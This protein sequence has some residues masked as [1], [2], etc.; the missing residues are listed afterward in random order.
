[1]YAIHHRDA[2]I[3]VQAGTRPGNPLK[4]NEDALVFN[5]SDDVYGVIDGV[6]ALA[7]YQSDLGFTGGYLAAQLLA[8]V[9]QTGSP[10][11]NLKETVLKANAQLNKRMREACI[12]L[13]DK[14]ALWGAVFAVIKIHD[15]EI[16][17]VQSG[18]CMLLAKYRDGGVRAFTRNQVAA[19]DRITLDAKRQLAESGRLTD[20]EIVQQLQPLF[21]KNRNKANTPDG[22]SVM[23]GDPALAD[24]MES[25]RFPKGDIHKIYAVS[26]GMFHFIE[27]DD[28]PDKWQKFAV[29]LEE[30]GIES[31]MD[32]LTLQEEFDVLCLKYP[33][34]KIS[35]DK[36]AVVLE[37]L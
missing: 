22:Y 20:E 31:F 7:S 29:Q 11:L 25:G 21:K 1:M 15:S 3:D 34:H 9:L 35:D 24:C 27:N 19:F 6:S 33:R 30:Q 32:Q 16:E 12:G 5:P 26:D 28:D 4:M 17:F 10:D 2:Y 18:D 8:E 36:S 14:W 23:N 37:L 13:S